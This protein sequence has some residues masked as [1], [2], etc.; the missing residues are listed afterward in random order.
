MLK[1]INKYRMMSF[2]EKTLFSTKVSVIFNLFLAL[3]KIV[4]SFFFGVFFLVAG[5][6]NLFIMLAKV[7]CLM[8]EMFPH[9]APFKKRNML[10]GLFLMFAG[11]EYG[12]YMARLIFSDVNVMNYDMF[13]G[14]AIAFV[15]FVEMGFAIKG[16]FNSYGKGHYY[17]N[18]KL[19]NLCSA[20]TA[21]VLTEI[22]LTSFAAQTDTRLINGIFG[23]GIS[24]VIILISIYIFI[25]P[26]VSIVDRKH[27]VYKKIDDEIDNKSMIE[28]KL[29]NSRFYGNYK[30]VASIKDNIA[31]GNIIKEK[32]PIFKWNIYIL[33]L[34]IVLSEILI[35]P[36]AIGA[37]IFHFNDYKII[38][39][40]DEE[41]FKLGYVKINVEEK[42][43]K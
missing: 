16:C 19:I 11:I 23:I 43:V 28:I 38:K 39:V 31:D 6:V 40:L 34:V 5:I 8:G 36:Y 1:Y 9:R 37:L 15:S 32:S 13:L 26:K 24:F 27:N 21:I 25:A 7:Q 22:A 17:R 42:E 14:I 12:I 41:M 33:I 20:L 35:F 10:I 18:I 30:Y 29:S 2:K 3:G 4:L